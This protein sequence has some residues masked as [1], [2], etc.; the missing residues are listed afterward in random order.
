MPGQCQD[1]LNCDSGWSTGEERSD[2]IFPKKSIR[3]REGNRVQHV[4]PWILSSPL[5]PSALNFSNTQHAGIGRAV[6][7]A[8]IQTHAY[9]HRSQRLQACCILTVDLAPVWPV[10]HYG[11]T[12]WK[13]GCDPAQH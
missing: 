3:T 12:R 4:L 8:L 13:K 10:Q 7:M 6:Q 1:I 5:S 11:S 2:S 9:A